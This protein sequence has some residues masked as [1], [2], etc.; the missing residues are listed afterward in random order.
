MTEDLA[1]FFGKHA[2]EIHGS[3]C[4]FGDW[5]G[6]PMDNNHF[7]TGFEIEDDYLKL[8]FNEGETLEIW[9]ASGFDFQTKK[10][11]IQ[12]ARR[13]RWEWFYYGRPK[14]KENRFAEEHVV[15][16]GTIEA[17][18]NATWYPPNFKPSPLEPAVLIQ[19]I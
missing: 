5:F 6:K 19:R 18:T 10:F 1:C 16:S 13:V 14:L 15:G 9:G 8:S 12:N 3:L 11:V 17:T 4:V 7:V 2:S